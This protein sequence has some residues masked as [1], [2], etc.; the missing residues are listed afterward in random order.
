MTEFPDRSTLRN[1]GVVHD[2]IEAIRQLKARY[3]RLMDTKQWDDLEAVFVPDVVIDS[4]GEG[5]P[6]THGA[7]AFVAMLRD[8]IGDAVTVHHGHMPE[9]TLTSTTMAEGVWA[10]ED[11]IWWPDGAPLRHLHG[12]GHYHETYVKVLDDLPAG[13]DAST[14][15][16]RASAAAHPGPWRIASMRLT[17]LRRDL[18]LADGNVVS[19]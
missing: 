3:F 14:L 15:R 10:M 13:V 2:D 4:S 19:L 5:G 9:I 17:R 16:P 7:A 1:V 6:V 12:Y 8:Q 11:H 18:T